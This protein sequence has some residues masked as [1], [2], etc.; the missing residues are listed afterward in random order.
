[1][2]TGQERLRSHTGH[3]DG[4]MFT[5]L[6]NFCGSLS[7]SQVVG[8][9]H[10]TVWSQLSGISLSTHCLVLAGTPLP[11]LGYPPVTENKW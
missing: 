6:L 2:E 7:S 3:T 10:C 5:A 9:V 1:M 4:F 11:E 8:L